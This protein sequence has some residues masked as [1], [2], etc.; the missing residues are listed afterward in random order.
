L[1]QLPTIERRD[2]LRSIGA[3]RLDELLAEP[4]PPDEPDLADK[5]AERLAWALEYGTA[6]LSLYIDLTAYNQHTV[7]YREYAVQFA[8]YHL[9]RTTRAGASQPSRDAFDLAH[10]N[11][12]MAHK[13]ERLPGER[14]QR[15]TVT[16]VV[17]EDETRW[18]SGKLYGFE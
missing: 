6:E 15:S 8:L 18:S 17:I 7:L 12:A 14:S 13:G 9:E 4:F 10:K 3:E 5:T 2:L 11:L 16:A 1:S